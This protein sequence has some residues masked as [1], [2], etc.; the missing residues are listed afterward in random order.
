MATLLTISDWK[1][2]SNLRSSI[3]LERQQKSDKIFLSLLVSHENAR[4]HFLGVSRELWRSNL[5]W[6]NDPDWGSW[7]NLVKPTPGCAAALLTESITGGDLF[8]SLQKHFKWQ[9]CKASLDATEECSWK[10]SISFIAVQE[11]STA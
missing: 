8:L 4:C 6:S 9:H 7:F 11:A 1:Y 3:Y 2:F 10:D 5:F